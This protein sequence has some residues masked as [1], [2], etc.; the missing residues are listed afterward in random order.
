MSDVIEMSALE[1]RDAIAAGDVSAAE[2]AQPY[3]DAIEAVEPRVAAFNEVLPERAMD[4]ARQ[5]DADR[6]AG[7][8]PLHRLGR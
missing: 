5:V 1:L 3:L 6:A 4:R 2:A 8:P 7:R